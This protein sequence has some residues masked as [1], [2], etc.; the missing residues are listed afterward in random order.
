MVYGEYVRGDGQIISEFELGTHGNLT[1]NRGTDNFFQ[2]HHG[3]QDAWAQQRF[4]GLGVYDR[5]QAKA[6]LLRSRNIE[7]GSR[8]T[9]RGLINNL[10]KRKESN[11]SNKNFYGRK[12]GIGYRPERH[13]C[14]C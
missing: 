4:N 14:T 13:W 7:G 12:T 6:L 3:I 9:P 8:G 2:S 1:N 10:R 11:D 5:D